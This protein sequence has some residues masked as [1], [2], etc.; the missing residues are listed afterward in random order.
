MDFKFWKDN[1]LD[2]E[3]ELPEEQIK[4]DMQ[5]WFKI[6]DNKLKLKQWPLNRI[7]RCFMADMDYGSWEYEKPEVLEKLLEIA[8]GILKWN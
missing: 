6:E 5:E 3:Y 2:Q 8:R 7:V 1:L 4:N